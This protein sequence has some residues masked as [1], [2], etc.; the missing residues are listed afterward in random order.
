MVHLYMYYVCLLRYYMNV[1][2]IYC[3]ES[4]QTGS[5]YKLVSGIWIDSQYG[6]PF[7]K[8]FF[9]ICE[10][11]YQ[12]P[13]PGNMKWSKVPNKIDGKY[14]SLYE[15]LIDLYF[16]YNNAGKMFFKVIIADESYNMADQYYHDNDYEKGFYK[17]YYYLILHT[18]RRG[19]KY[20]IRIASRDPCRK[21]NRLTEMDRLQDLHKCLNNGFRKKMRYNY[22]ENIVL[23]VEARPAKSRLLIQLTDIL[24]GAV[25]YQWCEEHK[26]TCARQSKVELSYYIAEKLNRDNL[27]FTT[28]W[29]DTRFN[30]FKLDPGSR[31]EKAPHCLHKP[32]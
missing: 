19:E 22:N 13:P 3:D 31:N 29:N 21:V 32:L 28:D 9:K 27:I 15:E 16:K 30:I 17:L 12:I 6:W 14:Y 8:D 23:S 5:K 7:V 25:G 1:N 10:D 26:K 2:K 20:H 18:L 24:M 11:K 4:R